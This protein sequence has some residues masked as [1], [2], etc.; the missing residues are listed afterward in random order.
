M[1]SDIYVI[2]FL[3][4]TQRYINPAYSTSKECSSLPSI[5]FLYIPTAHYPLQAFRYFADARAAGS[6]LPTCDEIRGGAENRLK[7]A[8]RQLNQSTTP[9]PL[10]YP[11]NSSPLSL[12]VYVCGCDVR[13]CLHAIISIIIGEGGGEGLYEHNVRSRS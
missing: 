6:A 10:L 12:A 11:I 8:Y 4:L 9:I 7:T 1:L 3:I 2:K 5:E 13:Y